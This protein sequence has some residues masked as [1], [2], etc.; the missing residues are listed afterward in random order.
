VAKNTMNISTMNI[1][2]R[3][4]QPRK[5]GMEQL[6]I[7]YYLDTS[8]YAF[9]TADMS[10]AEMIKGYLRTLTLESQNAVLDCIVSRQMH[11]IDVNAVEGVIPTIR[12]AGIQQ[13]EW[14]HIDGDGLAVIIDTAAKEMADENQAWRAEKGERLLKNTIGYLREDYTANIDGEKYVAAMPVEMAE[15]ITD[16]W[17]AV[18]EY[19]HAQKEQIHAQKEYSH[20]LQ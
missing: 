17:L 18:R 7:L 5:K 4:L 15:F 16:C 9:N 3:N 20:A 19:S 12:S 10:V 13:Q 14:I 6:G 1:S 11:E 8:R 2:T